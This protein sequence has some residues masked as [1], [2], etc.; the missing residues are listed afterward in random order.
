MFGDGEG[1]QSNVKFAVAATYDKFTAQWKLPA[2]KLRWVDIWSSLLSRFSVEEI[3][4]VANYCVREFRRPPIPVEFIELCHRI[5]DGRPL[6]EPIV[7]KIERM[8]YLILSN[9]DFKTGEVSN[10]EISDACLIAASIASLNAYAEMAP[11]VP[12]EGIG[13][14]LTCRTKMFFEEALRWQI[15]SKEGKGYWADT[16][17]KDC[18]EN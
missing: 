14:E 12:K 16:F 13:T 10:S 17:L 2:Q 18:S 1:L 8:A 5:R 9:A 11:N 3:N 7:S 4:S 6:S 15:D